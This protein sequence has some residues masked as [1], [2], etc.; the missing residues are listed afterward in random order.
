M[1]KKI[2]LLSRDDVAADMARKKLWRH[3][4]AY[5]NA[6]RHTHVYVHT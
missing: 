3:M 2:I 5:E 4:T 6:T 1:N